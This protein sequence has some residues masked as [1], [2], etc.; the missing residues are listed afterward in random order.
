MAE[1]VQVILD[2]MVPP[3]YDLLERG[4]FSQAE[5]NAIVRRRTEFER[6]LL[7]VPGRRE[8]YRC[9]LRYERDLERLRVLRTRKLK[10]RKNNPGDY[11]GRG[12]I[13]FIYSRMVKRF[14]DDVGV[15][16]EYIRYCKEDDDGASERGL[17]S[18]VG[19][20]KNQNRR[21]SSLYATAL[22]LHPGATALW[23][24]AA[25][26]EF[27]GRGSPRNA[28]MLLQ[29]AL[30]TQGEGGGKVD[31]WVQHFVL[32]LHAIQRLRG[33]EAVR[34]LE[35]EE[36]TTGGAT[37]EEEEEDVTAAQIYSGSLA[38][39]VYDSA[40]EVT[41]RKGLTAQFHSRFLNVTYGFPDM[42]KLRQHI[43]K[44][45]VE[46]LDELGSQGWIALASYAVRSPEEV[47]ELWEECKKKW[48][49]SKLKKRVADNYL[50]L[51][52]LDTAVG[53]SKGVE[54]MLL[55]TFNFSQERL[56]DA[57]KDE[58][59]AI[60]EWIIET[61]SLHISPVTS[62]AA[63][64]EHHVHLLISF[65]DE[66]TAVETAQ[67][68]LASGGA[69]AALPALWILHA[70]MS[71]HG[72]VSSPTIL[73]EGADAMRTAGEAQ[74][75]A[76]LLAELLEVQVTVHELGTTDVVGSKRKRPKPDSD[77]KKTIDRLLLLS[78][79]CRVVTGVIHRYF[80]YLVAASED[81]GSRLT[82]YNLARNLVDKFL[83]SYN[84]GSVC[85]KDQD[86]AK[87]V[88]MLY[89]A[90]IA[91]EK[92][93]LTV[94]RRKV[95]VGKETAAVEKWR[96]EITVATFRQRRAYEQAVDFFHGIKNNETAERFRKER[97]K[98]FR[99]EL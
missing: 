9:Y 4:V 98:F 38:K 48:K 33:R 7:T 5:I 46:D 60:T 32:E 62:S 88:D 25:S 74:G 6:S 49:I 12:H 8:D 41:E 69:A 94:A 16:V 17:G 27:F 20:S 1:K 51:S 2:R 82:K 18:G 15:V 21:L 31:I 13:H 92:S 89:C 52:I 29:R 45:I 35:E 11:H 53:Y 61:S 28:R 14:P 84:G 50:Y 93:N 34:K 36:G 42:T 80:C 96:K 43:A 44:S 40:V 54:D 67:K 86:A 26:H 66:A 75:E 57:D 23:I 68:A 81:G 22:R 85:G 78:S 95:L 71:S 76:A 65:G 39:I 97:D 77:I 72:S 59:R 63:L 10:H 58:H 47:K 83:Q 55:A 64:V 56:C 19:L 30:R 24:D 79:S 87:E 99:L 3:L 70:R 37:V 91:F 73:K 90:C